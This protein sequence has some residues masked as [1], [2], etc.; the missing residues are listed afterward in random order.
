MNSPTNEIVL[1]QSDS[2][3]ELEVRL[4]HET[5]W[6]NRQQMSVLF[7]RDIK[8]IGKHINNA[9]KEELSPDAVVADF[10]TTQ[11]FP[12]IAKNATLAE[13]PT[14]AN[15]ATVQIEG[16]REVLRNIEYYNLDMILSVG[17]RV[18]SNQG[19]KFR[20]WANRVLK[21]YLLRGYAINQ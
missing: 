8:T 2:V 19:I 12:T 4:E 20:A 16:N 3:V 15:F 9:L 14:V 7:D 13:N 18:K 21:D 6:L 5:V 11:Q 17:Y 1:Y 10:A